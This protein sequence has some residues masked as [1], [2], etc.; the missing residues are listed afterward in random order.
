[1][2]VIVAGYNVDKNLLDNLPNSKFEG[3]VS[4]ESVAAAYA[5]ISRS[6]LAVDE[7]RKDALLDIEKTRKSNTQIVHEYGHFSVAEHAVFNIDIKGIS[8]LAVEYLEHARLASYTEKSFRYCKLQDDYIVPSEIKYLGL[9]Y[10][11]E[12]LLEQQYILYTKLSDRIHK[13]YIDKEDGEH[14]EWT[15]NEVRN[16][17]KKQSKQLRSL[18]KDQSRYCSSLSSTTQLGMTINVR[19]LEYLIRRLKSYKITELHE[20]ANKLFNECQPYVP[21]LLKYCD[22]VSYIK[23][24]YENVLLSADCC[25]F[26]SCG[27]R[28][29]QDPE[30]SFCS[31]SSP[32]IGFYPPNILT[33]CSS[34][35]PDVFG[36]MSNNIKLSNQRKLEIY[37]SILKHV[38][39]Y[40]SLP[41]E[42]EFVDF[43]FEVLVSAS[44]YAQLKKHRMSSQIRSYYI[45]DFNYIPSMFRKVYLMQDFQNLMRK[46]K[47]IYTKVLAKFGFSIASYVLTQSN[48]RKVLVKMNARDLYHFFNLRCDKHAGHEIRTL[49]AKMLEICKEKEPMLFMLACGKDDFERTKEELFKE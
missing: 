40:D 13:Y 32:F 28:Y 16:T 9:E 22:S 37:S 20:L 2:E 34:V 15:K 21:S 12:S 27:C 29:F 43:T 49:A 42:F 38:N 23:L 24:G 11:F 47:A 14:L 36:V 7:L 5:R 45:D 41:R 39:V 33:Y 48:M 44:C 30:I 10:E 6:D 17:S 18:A 46:V 4:P 19:N 3:V 8:R 1:M 35:N 31:Y 26:R 25:D